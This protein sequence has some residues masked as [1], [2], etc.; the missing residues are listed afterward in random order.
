M[1]N[2]FLQTKN[3]FMTETK[4]IRNDIPRQEQFT[5]LQRVFFWTSGVNIEIL[6]QVPLEKNKFF[7]I[8][9]T[10]LF[11]ALMA[12]MAGGYACYAVFQSYGLSIVFGLFWGALILNLDRYIV[13]TVHFF[14][15]LSL[16]MMFSRVMPRLI[17]A[18]FLGVIIA[19][20][21]ELKLFERE[22]NHTIEKRMLADLALQEQRVDAL[23]KDEESRLLNDL[24]EL[25]RNADERTKQIIELQVQV[26]KAYDIY[27]KELD[28]SGGSGQKGVGPIFIEKKKEFERL[29]QQLDK[30]EGTNKNESLKSQERITYLEKQLSRTKKTKEQRLANF[31]VSNTASNGLAAKIVALNELSNENKSVMTAKW[32]ISL[33][34]IFIEVAPILFKII[35]P[36]GPYEYILHRKQ[37]EAVLSEKWELKQLETQ[38]FNKMSQYETKMA[39]ELKQ[40]LAIYK[41]DEDELLAEEAK[42]K[43]TV[44]Q[45]SEG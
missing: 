18:I 45:L 8:G 17:M 30:Y 24:E 3:F 12:F 42:E 26:N 34:F 43:T 23:F 15:K 10:I 27:M 35:T 28:G 32:L 2:P 16:R 40:S 21:L 22:I 20:P 44:V 7:G 33:L 37:T 13:C 1:S 36:K 41:H 9:G 6:K 5:L 4:A 19:V 39:Y 29:S 38:H 14:E 11:T 25:K 31:K